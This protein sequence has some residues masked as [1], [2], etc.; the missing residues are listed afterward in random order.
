MADTPAGW[1][2]AE[3]RTA[4]EN[5]G[6]ESV[7]REFLSATVLNAHAAAERLG[8][9]LMDL[10]AVNLLA[11]AGPM[12]VG[13]LGTRLGTPAATT[14]RVVDRLEDAGYAR[15]VRGDTDRRRV[16]V[17][18]DPERT[19]AVDEAFAPTRRHLAGLATRYSPEQIALLFDMLAFTTGGFKRATAEIRDER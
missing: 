1:T 16:R 4:A 8:L 13:E 18:V 7:F 3:V 2:S 10:Q 15:R 17:D 19:R 5:A 6:G 9:R 12:T 11:D 14:T